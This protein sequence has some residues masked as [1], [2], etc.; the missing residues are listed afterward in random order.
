LTTV[1]KADFIKVRLHRPA[2]EGITDFTGPYQALTAQSVARIDLVTKFKGIPL[3]NLIHLRHGCPGR[4]ITEQL[5][6]RVDPSFQLPPEWSCSVCMSEKTKSLPSHPS[7]CTTLLPLG[8]R[9]QM[10]FGFYKIPSIRGFTSFLAVVEAKTSYRWCFLRRSKH[11]PI[12]LCAWFIKHARTVF[13]FSVVVIRTDGGGELWGS[14][15]WRNR[16]IE[17]CQVIIEPT[18]KENSAS[19][20]KSERSI[21]VLGVQAQLLLCMSALDLIFWCFALLHGT[22][23]LNLRPREGGRLCPFTEVFGTKA[24][25]DALR[26]FGSLVYQVDRRYTRRRPESATKKG[27][28]LGL[29]GTPQICVFMDS[30]TK[31]FNYGHHYI[32]DELD[33]HKL[34]N[35]RSPAARM[36]AGDP[37]PA[38]ATDTIHE[39]LTQLEPDISP[40]LTDSLVNHHIPHLPPTKTFGFVLHPHPGFGRLRVISFIPGS[41]AY[42]HLNDKNLSGTFLLAIN[43]I[44]IRSVTEIALVLDDFG[45]RPDKYQHTRL[46]GF[47]FL[48][49]R[50]DKADI[51]PDILD[52]QA[53]DHASLRSVFSLCLEIHSLD[54]TMNPDVTDELLLLPLYQCADFYPTFIAELFI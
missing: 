4:K 27:I 25:I 13:G 29:H 40:W 10:D 17:E 2:I 30:L 33:L 20:G 14:H 36:L 46:T 5:V 24:M 52:L 28:W 48:F 50:L 51:L 15:K 45:S 44:A 7:I 18:G 19:N 22:L 3:L 11:P 54:A 39:A 34:P 16:L 43:G 23:L 8:A 37:L 32:V 42:E 49:G 41:Y 53:A 9:L 12:N 35:D 47:T 38:D 31:R 6:R 21:G 1:G 26:I